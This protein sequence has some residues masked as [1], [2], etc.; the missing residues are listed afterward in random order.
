MIQETILP[1]KWSG[2]DKQDELFNSY[3]GVEF[4]D[5]FGV[6][7][8]GDKFSSISVDYGK[9]IIEGY[10]EDGEKVIIKQMFIAKPI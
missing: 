7:K 2:W 8:N 3:Y 9:G 10:S 4:T 5:D 6:F 1:F